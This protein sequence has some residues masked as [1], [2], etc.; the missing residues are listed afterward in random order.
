[1]VRL[2]E[3]VTWRRPAGMTAKPLPSMTFKA[4]LRCEHSV[5]LTT[6]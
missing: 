1:M 6:H 5:Y 3:M 4:F 2:W